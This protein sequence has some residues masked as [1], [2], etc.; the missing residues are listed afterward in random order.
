MK[1]N[2]DS[3]KLAVIAPPLNAESVSP[4]DSV[5]L[6][7]YSRAIYIGTAGDLKVDMVGVGTV[8]FTNL[9]VGMWPMRVKR[10]YNTG[11]AAL[12]ILNLY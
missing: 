12:G 8:T 5:D 3:N 4:H 6:T 7:N 10:V 2:L 11:T 1:S 9:P